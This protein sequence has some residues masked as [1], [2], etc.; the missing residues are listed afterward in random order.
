MRQLLLLVAGAAATVA[1]V[2]L[3]FVPAAFI[4][5]GLAVCAF[6]LLWQFGGNQ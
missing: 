3:V 6:A 5:G 1:G 4:V 2:A